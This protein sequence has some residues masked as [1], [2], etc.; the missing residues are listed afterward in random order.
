MKIYLDDLGEI[1]KKTGELLEGNAFYYH[2]T[3]KLFVLDREIRLAI[4]LFN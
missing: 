3:L 4:P 1:V 2:A